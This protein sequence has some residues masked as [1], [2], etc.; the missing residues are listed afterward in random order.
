M[1]VSVVGQRLIVSCDL[2]TAAN[3][4]PVNLFVE[5]EGRHGLQLANKAAAGLKAETSDG[6]PRRALAF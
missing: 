6:K 4:I 1:A 5:L 3:R 2:S